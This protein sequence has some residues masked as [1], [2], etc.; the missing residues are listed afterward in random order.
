MKEMSA[1][2]ID[3]N[4]E[5]RLI[6]GHLQVSSIVA[7]PGQNLIA[8][9]A[10]CERVFVFENSTE[11]EPIRVFDAHKRSVRSMIHLCDD[12]I[13]SVDAAGTLLTWRG[14]TGNVL[15]QLKVT[16]GECWSITKT[17]STEVLVGTG[18][19]Q[20]V[21]VTHGD[22]QHLTVRERL[23]DGR[24][25][26]ITAVGAYQNVFVAV[27]ELNLQIWNYANGKL[28]HSIEDDIFLQVAVNEDF[29]LLGGEDCKVYV[30]EK[31]TPYNLMRTID[32]RKLHPS[33][34]DDS[35]IADI[36]FLNDDTAM[37]TAGHAGL[38]FI[39]L[40]SG[41]CICTCPLKNSVR[42][43]VL[44]DG[45]LLIGGMHGCCYIFKPP[46][47]VEISIAE[48]KH[49]SP[50]ETI[51]IDDTGECMDNLRRA[52]NVGLS[53]KE[54]EEEAGNFMEIWKRLETMECRINEQ[55]SEIQTMKL[56]Y[57]AQEEKFAKMELQ[58][59]KQEGQNKECEK[60]IEEFKVEN[61]EHAVQ[62]AKMELSNTKQHG[63]MRSK[64]E[65]MELH[66]KAIE[67]RIARLEI[68]SCAKMF[69]KS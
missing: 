33:K 51:V 36:S 31:R 30:Y 1:P 41:E 44:N 6:C 37:V 20:V 62:I 55:E 68:L 65:I 8:V 38:F 26:D 12:V 27:G 58:I 4:P 48:Y 53:A 47:V 39:S 16:E 14:T 57:K 61:K 64:F 52:L 19:G 17:S 2:V 9:S 69:N 49:G 66:N 59:R 60:E 42:A 13:A 7:L 18:N 25:Q 23:T 10:S 43:A 40:L 35:W 5:V 67:E 50:A 34:L 54:E 15:D 46:Q 56:L 11:G 3:M 22:G 32:V 45:R 63:K 28:L 24:H 21:L 29:I